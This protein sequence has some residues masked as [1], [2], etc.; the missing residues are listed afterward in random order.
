MVTWIGDLLE[1]AGTGA[2]AA[3]EGCAAAWHRILFGP[4]ERLGPVESSTFELCRF[5]MHS[6]GSFDASL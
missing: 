2:V 1:R 6:Q 5:E 3:A 4:V